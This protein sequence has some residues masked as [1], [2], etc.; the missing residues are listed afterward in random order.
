V[1]GAVYFEMKE[2]IEVTRQR[3]IDRTNRDGNGCWNWNGG[4][5]RHGY[6]HFYLFGKTMYAHRASYVLFMGDIPDEMCV[7]HRCDNR[8]C[9]NPSH[10]FLGSRT[11]NFVDMIQ[12]GRGWF[13][14]PRNK[15]WHRGTKITMEDAEAIRILRK[16]GRTTTEIA[17]MFNVGKSTI[18]DVCSGHT[19]TTPVNDKRRM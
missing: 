5:N 6:G 18:K 3:M 4:V 16:G 10:L 15:N 2:T 17:R 13:Q 1:S 14:K 19:W 8:K 7:L 12:K 9:V 11:E